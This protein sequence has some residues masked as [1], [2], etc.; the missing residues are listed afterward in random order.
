MFCSKTDIKVNVLPIYK[1][2][3]AFLLMQLSKILYL[4]VRFISST[5]YSV[6]HA[7]LCVGDRIKK[8]QNSEDMWHE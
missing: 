2:L 6:L 7:K 5:C 1:E 8:D 3:N 4:S